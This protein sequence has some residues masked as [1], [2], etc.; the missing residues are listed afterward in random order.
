ML[1]QGLVWLDGTVTTLLRALQAKAEAL[2]K[3]EMLETSVSQANDRS[4]RL[5]EQLK[6]MQEM[7]AAQ[8]AAANTEKVGCTVRHC[9]T[10]RP[11]ANNHAV[12]VSLVVAG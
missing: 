5:A 7:M 3:V 4:T 8:A 1:E 11:C 12:L 2:A 10:A 6:G 9:C